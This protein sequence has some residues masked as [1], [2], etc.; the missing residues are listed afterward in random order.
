MRNFALFLYVVF[1][2]HMLCNVLIA[3]ASIVLPVLRVH[4]QVCRNIHFI[5]T[6]ISKKDL[7][8][9]KI[10]PTQ[11]TEA[12]GRLGSGVKVC[13]KEFGMGLSRDGARHKQCM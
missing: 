9:D 11:K 3:F 5:H 6:E 2:Y 1:F 12:Q 4:V 7:H 10:L 13:A 8:K